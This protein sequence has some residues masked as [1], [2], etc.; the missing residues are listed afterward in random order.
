M[1]KRLS[2][3]EELKETVERLHGGIATYA[4]TV[5]VKEVFERK[6]IWQ[7]DVEV[8]DLQNNPKATRAC[9]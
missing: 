1:K 5:A 7:G 6:T 4:G 8:F 3:I 2:P 9:A